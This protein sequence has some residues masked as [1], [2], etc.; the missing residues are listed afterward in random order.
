MASPACADYQVLPL[1]I[2]N[3]HLMGVATRDEKMC[4]YL[5]ARGFIYFLKIFL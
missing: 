5:C 2:T 3:K 1:H 4:H